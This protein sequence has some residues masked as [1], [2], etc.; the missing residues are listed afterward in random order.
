MVQNAVI[1]FYHQYT[2]QNFSPRMAFISEG[3]YA[4]PINTRDGPLATGHKFLPK[5]TLPIPFD[6]F[7]RDQIR[8][9]QL[10]RIFGFAII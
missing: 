9:I 10:D 3:L 2:T 6:N 8:K 5:P 4:V 7:L 1:Y